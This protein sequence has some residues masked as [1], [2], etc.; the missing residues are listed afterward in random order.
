MQPERAAF[1]ETCQVYLAGTN[2][3]SVPSPSAVQ[4]VRPS[5]VLICHHTQLLLQPGP[6]MIVTTSPGWIANKNFE[7]LS[8]WSRTLLGSG[9][10]KLTI[11]WSPTCSSDGEDP[12]QACQVNGGLWVGVDVENNVAVGA[13]VS[14]GISVGAAVW[15]GSTVAVMM[16]GESSE[17]AGVGV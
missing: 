12:G 10:F 17:A 6:S 7:V 13:L 16:M 11:A 5:W 9:G 1:Q 14:P 3:Y 4:P 8:G 2:Q 15:L